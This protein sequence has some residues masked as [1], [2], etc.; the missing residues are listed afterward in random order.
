MI[1]TYQKITDKALGRFDIKNNK[2][3]E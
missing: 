1:S 2:M 3:S